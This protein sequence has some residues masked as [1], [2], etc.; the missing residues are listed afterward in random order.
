MINPRTCN[1]YT[2]GAVTA[3]TYGS[4]HPLW[5]LSTNKTSVP[6]VHRSLHCNRTWGPTKQR[7]AKDNCRVNG[8]MNA[9]TISVFPMWPVCATCATN[10]RHAASRMVSAATKRKGNQNKMKA[11]LKLGRIF[12]IVIGLHLSWFII[13]LLITLS[14]AGQRPYSVILFDEIEKGHHDA[15][16]VLLQILDDGRLTDGQGRIVDFKN[17]VIIMTSNIGSDRILEFSGKTDS[18]AYE[19][20]K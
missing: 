13:A 17:T 5:V 16:N 6:S 11:H 9:Q 10:P 15:F 2:K 12:G 20:M 18:A 19:V 1:F 8:M 3:S 7:A 14:L 4:F